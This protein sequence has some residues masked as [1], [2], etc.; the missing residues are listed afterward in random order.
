MTT[1]EIATLLV[2]VCEHIVCM[3]N[4]ASL[5]GSTYAK[6]IFNRSKRPR[7]GDVVVIRFTI[8][9]DPLALVGVLK[10]IVSAD[11]FV[12]DTLDGRE[13]RWSN[14]EANAVPVNY[15]PSYAFDDVE[16]MFERRSMGLMKDQAT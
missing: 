1:R 7:V 9:A 10:Q 16:E 11:T 15:P 13:M 3:G 12:I 14:V 8:G 5:G 2:A 4:L 6:A